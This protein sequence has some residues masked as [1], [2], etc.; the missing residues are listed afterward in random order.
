MTIPSRIIAGDTLT[1]TTASADYPASAGWTL[2]HALTP[3]TSTNDQL[4]F[5][6]IADGDDYASTVAAATTAQWAA[7]DYTWAAY[8]TKLTQR[9]TIAR[10]T[11]TVIGD[12]AQ[13]E[14]GYD[15]RSNASK[16]VDAIDAMLAGRATQDQLEYEISVGGSMRRLRSMTPAELNVRRD[17]YAKI[18]QLEEAQ[19]RA[20]SGLPDKRRTYVRFGRG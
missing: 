17:Y 1:F 16:I 12:P 19:E 2:T 11:T 9:F 5:D 3:R 10:G 13:A 14:P 20:T 7:D 4:T 18:V 6:A 8:V 15:P